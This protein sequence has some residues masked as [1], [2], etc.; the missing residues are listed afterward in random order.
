MASVFKGYWVPVG[1]LLGVSV[2][3]SFVMETQNTVH[4]YWRY[5]HFPGPE[6]TISRV[7]ASVFAAWPMQYVVFLLMA[8]VLVPA[9]APVFWDRQES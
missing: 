6:V 9:L 8:S 7:E 4:N 2:M 1:A 5:T 3:L